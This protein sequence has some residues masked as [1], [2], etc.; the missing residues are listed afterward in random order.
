MCL[1]CTRPWILC[2]D[3]EET[4]TRFEKRQS[5]N[6]KMSQLGSRQRCGVSA[7]RWT[8]GREEGPGDCRETVLRDPRHQTLVLIWRN[9]SRRPRP[10]LTATQQQ[11][12]KPEGGQRSHL[13]DPRSL[14]G[15]WLQHLYLHLS[16]L[17]PLITTLSNRDILLEV[18]KC[19]MT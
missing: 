14:E 10:G 16:S 9:R 15:L 2:S 5:H 4:K 1:A 11:G 12:Q 3:P 18:G 8:S 19:L 17:C 7:A 6:L 13:S